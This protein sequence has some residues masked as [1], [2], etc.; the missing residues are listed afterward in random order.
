M[1]E[2]RVGGYEARKASQRI[3]EARR[4]PSLFSQTEGE[5]VLWET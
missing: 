3:H 1:D 2:Q 5:K 4:E